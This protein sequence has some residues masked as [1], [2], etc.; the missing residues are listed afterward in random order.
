MRETLG[1]KIPTKLNEKNFCK[2][3]SVNG[4]S[5]LSS[6]F[7]R[8]VRLWPLKIPKVTCFKQNPNLLILQKNLHSLILLTRVFL[9]NGVKNSNFFIPKLVLIIFCKVLEKVVVKMD[10]LIVVSTCGRVIF[11]PLLKPL[12]VFFFFFFPCNYLLPL[13]NDSLHTQFLRWQGL[14][15]I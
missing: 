10:R 11:S 7:R 4:K 13:K 2:I 3:T 5:E 15:G 8:C 14:A 12:L 1:H 6:F 9:V